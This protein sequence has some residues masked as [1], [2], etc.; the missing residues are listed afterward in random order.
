MRSPVFPIKEGMK[1]KKRIKTRIGVGS[2]VKEKVGEIR[3][4]IREGR[5]RRMRKE[6]VVCVQDVVE[7]KIYYYSY[8]KSTCGWC[9]GSLSQTFIVSTV[10]VAGS[11]PVRKEQNLFR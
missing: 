2:V 8:R 3:D 11:S 4:N 1:D 7:K 10:E 5:S 9:I 6:D